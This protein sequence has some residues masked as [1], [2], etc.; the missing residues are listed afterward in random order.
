MPL[1]NRSKVLGHARSVVYIAGVF[2]A[3]SA[4]VDARNLAAASTLLMS[5]AKLLDERISAAK[6]DD[7]TP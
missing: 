4:F 2:I 5:V 7:E 1:S 6:K 3:F